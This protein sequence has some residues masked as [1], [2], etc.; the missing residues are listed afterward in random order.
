MGT[1]ML[2]A[3]SWTGSIDPSAPGSGGGEAPARTACSTAGSGS[4]LGMPKNPL[5]HAHA[6]REVA[7]S[8]KVS[9]LG[10]HATQ[11]ALASPVLKLKM[12]QLRHAVWP[13]RSWKRPGPHLRH[14]GMPSSGATD[15]A[16]HS[17]QGAPPEL[18]NPRAHL[19][20]VK[21]CVSLL[22]DTRSL[23]S[24]QGGLLYSASTPQPRAEKSYAF[25]SEKSPTVPVATP[26]LALAVM[27][28]ML[29]MPW[30][31]CPSTKGP[32]AWL[33]AATWKKEVV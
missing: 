3:W 24:G 28:Q 31:H 9:A 19:W 25:T 17:L 4:T 5:L 12:S 14:E 18:K 26:G 33:P 11:P 29:R 1:N 7:P 23:P 6:A 8:V 2:P 15:P 13:G 10:P 22:S 27:I 21:A 16:G 30:L 32:S 20:Q